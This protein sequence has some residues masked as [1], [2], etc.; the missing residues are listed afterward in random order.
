MPVGQEMQATSAAD[1]PADAAVLDAGRAGTLAVTIVVP[2][3]NRGALIAET[4]QALLALE[5]PALEIIVADQSTDDVTRRTIQEVARGDARVRYLHSATIG[6]S[7]NRNLGAMLSSAD[8]VAYTDDDCIVTTEW[9]QA[10]VE[11]FANPAVEAVYGRL[12]PREHEARTGTEVGL[13]ASLERAEYC[14]KLPPWY[15]GHGG[16]MAFRRAALLEVGGFDPLLGAGGILRSNED[17]DITYR[18]LAANKR[19][20]YRPEALAYHKHWKSWDAQKQM[21]RAYG[22][23][24]GAQF[25]KYIRC[26]DLYGVQLL[27]TWV[28]QL[29]VRRV[30]SGLLK[31]RSRKVIYLGYCQLVYPWIGVWKARTYP[32]DRSHMNYISPIEGYT[33]LPQRAAR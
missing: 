25:A 8:V 12:L 4:L 22:I 21:E 9:L 16:N 24:A 2:T 32:V 11:E 20:V 5:Y 10:I 23:G 31:W 19:I 15:V 1:R 27:R 13:K 28:W 3:R 14:G 29:G 6:S 33:L 30:G 17:G 18:L 26:R 7:A